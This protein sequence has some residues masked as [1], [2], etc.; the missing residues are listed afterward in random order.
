MPRCVL[1][2]FNITRLL[3]SSLLAP[4]PPPLLLL[5]QTLVR[6]TVRRL[7]HCR[8]TLYRR[9]TCVTLQTNAAATPLSIPPRSSSTL[10][11][12][13]AAAIPVGATL[14]SATRQLWTPTLRRNM[15]LNW[16]RE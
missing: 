13:L 10:R 7:S 1:L 3:P 16:L 14:L 15:P 2:Y 8:P 9:N 11:I 5:P 4:P 12:Q 6:R